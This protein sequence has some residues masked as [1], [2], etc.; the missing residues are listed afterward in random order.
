MGWKDVFVLAEGGEEKGRPALPAL[1][2]P[3]PPERAVDCAQLLAMLGKESVTLIDLSLSRAYRG[4]HISGAWFAIRSRLKRALERIAPQKQ[5][6]LTSEDGL[7]AGLAVADA[8]R[9]TQLPVRYLKGGNAAWRAAG[10]P[11]SG[12]ARMADEPVDAW[13]K[14]YERAD[15]TKGAMSEY[16]A[17]ETDLLSR[18]ARDGT[19][20]FATPR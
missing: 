20:N 17:W 7:L 13:L 14:P 4:G 1:G 3:P 2:T 11:M 6:V 9:L 18:I 8:S 19:C 10:Y 16:L 15:D 12:D 5:I